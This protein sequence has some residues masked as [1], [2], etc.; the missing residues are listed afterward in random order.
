MG[1]SI[2]NGARVKLQL[3]AQAGWTAE[4]VPGSPSG[5]LTGHLRYVIPQSP[6]Q[7]PGPPD[8]VL[9]VGESLP[10]PLDLGGWPLAALSRLKT[11]LLLALPPALAKTPSAAAEKWRVQIQSSRALV[12]ATGWPATLVHAV[13]TD[14]S[15]KPLAGCIA[16]LYRFVSY[17]AE[18]VFVSAIP[19]SGDRGRFAA[20]REPILNLLATGR[21]QWPRGEPP[22]LHH[23]LNDEP[24]S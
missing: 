10:L 4:S 1:S 16:A 18:A 11:T 14:G 20:L 19:A 5:L 9:I 3:A 17:G 7:A 8:S 24:Q 22:S 21:P 2:S 23:M 6:E 12:T 15:D 13:L